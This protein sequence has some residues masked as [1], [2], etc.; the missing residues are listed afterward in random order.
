[1]RTGQRGLT[2]A[3]NQALVRATSPDVFGFAAVEL[4][5]LLATVLFLSREGIRLA[6]LR[7]G[8]GKPAKEKLQSSSKPTEQHS[9]AEVRQAVNLAWLAVLLGLVVAG[10][11]VAFYSF[12]HATQAAG[13]G[14]Q[15]MVPTVALFAT[16]AILETLCEP[17]FILSQNALLYGLRSGLE[18]GAMFVRCITTSG[19][20]PPP[21]STSTA[22]P[23]AHYCLPPCCYTH[24]YVLIRA[25]LGPLAFGWAQVAFGAVLV[26][27]YYTYFARHAGS[28]GFVVSSI[29]QLLP[30]RPVSRPSDK[31]EPPLARW[32][33]VPTLRCE[34]TIMCVALF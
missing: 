11:A 8:I 1:M 20:S 3:L 7:S 25:G 28:E 5:L 13:E 10:C 18:M 19:V 12:R 9:K 17:A 22:R 4:E 29:G 2:F 30:G 33:A 26:A 16:G 15:H 6:L 27:G 23:R 21:N 32:G 14:I 24:R 31:Y 34:L